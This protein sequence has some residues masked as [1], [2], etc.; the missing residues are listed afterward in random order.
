MFFTLH[1]SSGHPTAEGPCVD[2]SSTNKSWLSRGSTRVASLASKD[3]VSAPVWLGGL[4]YP[5]TPLLCLLSLRV[6]SCTTLLLI[7][8]RPI[9]S[10]FIQLY[11]HSTVVYIYI[12]IQYI[13][14]SS[15]FCR[16]ETMMVCATLLQF[17]WSTNHWLTNQC[18]SPPALM[19]VIPLQ[20]AW[21]VKA[22]P[23]YT[24]NKWAS[25]VLKS[26]TRDTMSIYEW[27]ESTRTVGRW[28]WFFS[29]QCTQGKSWNSFER[30]SWY[31]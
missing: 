8:S 2:S 24:S 11:Y 6:L 5:R 16:L 17:R 31:M 9:C 10:D 22:R 23:T 20:T 18:I 1:V 30:D 12:C 14:Y 27:S 26:S 29:F 28:C 7:L 19:V 21:T 3:T 13:Q 25:E 4:C 15:F